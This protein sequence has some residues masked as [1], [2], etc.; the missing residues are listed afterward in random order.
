MKLL[1]ELEKL[2]GSLRSE[3]TIYIN[4]LT[5]KVSENITLLDGAF[6]MSFP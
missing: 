3:R 4:S 2:Y 1:I 5:N 6:E